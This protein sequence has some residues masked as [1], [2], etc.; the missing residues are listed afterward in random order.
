M[1]NAAA[2]FRDQDSDNLKP[3]WAAHH[4]LNRLGTPQEV[5]ETVIFLAVGAGYITGS[6]IFDRRRHPIGCF[7][8]KHSRA[9]TTHMINLTGK[10]IVISGGA[11]AL[12]VAI[13]RNLVGLGARVTALD[14][15]TPEEAEVSFASTPAG[16]S[17]LQCDASDTGQVRASLQHVSAAQGPIDVVCCHAGIVGV[18]KV[19][20]YDLE[21]FDALMKVNVRGSF[22]LAQEAAT[23]WLAD[24]RKGNLIFTTSWVHQVP[25]PEITPYAASKAAVNAMMRG[26]AKE[27]AP[28]GIRANA[29]APGI[30]AA[31]MALKS[32]N[33]ND[34]YRRRAS[35]AIPLGELQPVQSVADAM[36]FLCSDLSSYM[37]GSVLTVDGGCSLYPNT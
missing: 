13:C 11:G 22:V 15:A 37:T 7:T 28:N 30:V 26:F 23:R 6:D 18:S 2:T 8:H 16:L 33:E 21:E 14:I 1:H 35:I 4:P 36:A 25:W 5:A 19:Q 34:D 24:Q 27:L 31:G 10:S 9:R 20:S 3:A 12:G 17:Y 32:W 29:I